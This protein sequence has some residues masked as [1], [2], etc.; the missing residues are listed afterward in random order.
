MGVVS[1]FVSP[2]DEKAEPGLSVDSWNMEWFPSGDIE[3]L[4][5][6]DE[7]KRIERAAAEIRRRGVPEIL[8][9]QEI[10]DP[11]TCGKL[12]DAIGDQD[13]KPAVCSGFL[14]ISDGVTNLSLQ[15]QAVFTR[16]PVLASG[17]KEWTVTDYVYPPRGYAWAVVQ[18]EF[19][20]VAVFSLHLKSNYIPKDQDEKKQI[21]LNRLKREFAAEQIVK[22]V[23]DIRKNG[24][25]G[26]SVDA[27][28]VAGDFNVAAEDDRFAGEKTL[29]KLT[30]YG[31]RDAF[32]GIPEAERPTMPAN[33]W[34]PATTFDHIYYFGDLP[35]PA[36]R[37]VLPHTRTSDHNA[38]R[39]VFRT[40]DGASASGN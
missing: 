22:L 39:A 35:A 27:F 23:D 14:F 28:I 2:H 17:F 29:G 9:V 12:V 4:P 31:F 10:R 25:E 18:T 34:Y 8:L 38:I 3:P 5:E 6:K 26:V 36:V 15:Q 24:I 40:A 19:G 32:E 21:R 16:R 7:A 20:N 33:Q 1:L 13:F 30:D 11:A 37:R